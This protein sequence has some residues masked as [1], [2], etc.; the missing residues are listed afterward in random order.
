MG[1]RLRWSPLDFRFALH[2]DE[3]WLWGEGGSLGDGQK[4]SSKDIVAKQAHP[5]PSMAARVMAQHQTA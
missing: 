4:Q 5:Q 3:A 2:Y 1:G